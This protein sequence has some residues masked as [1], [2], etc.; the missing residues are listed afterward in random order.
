MNGKTETGNPL[1]TIKLVI[2]VAMLVAGVAGFYY[3]GEEPLFYRVGGL[4]GAAVLAALMAVQTE[5]GRAAWD[6]IV[7]SRTE[8]RKVVWPSR[9]ETVQTTLYVLVMVILVG[10]FLWLLDMFLLWAA[11]SLTGQG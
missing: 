7:T 8:V 5:V 1:D 4:L 3:Y 11:Q 6:F 10:I 2:A 9:T